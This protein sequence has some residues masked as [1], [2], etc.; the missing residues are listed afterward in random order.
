MA[1]AARAGAGA[2]VVMVLARAAVS[3]GGF[4]D[5]ALDNRAPHPL[6][7]H[8]NQQTKPTQQITFREV[9]FKW[10]TSLRWVSAL[11]Y[12][13]EALTVIEFAGAKVRFVFGSAIQRWM[14]FGGGLCFSKMANDRALATRASLQHTHN[15]DTT[16]PPRKTTTNP[17]S[18]AP[19]A[20]TRAAP[21]SC[22]ICC[23]TRARCA[24]R[25]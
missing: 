3:R 25:P 5:G 4:G 19:T 1:A 9:H 20:S 13:F 23:P 14:V 10:L 15:L 22:A 2:A 17:R 6:H 7:K 11:F 24:S 8:Q 18:R 16:P 12:A 21:A